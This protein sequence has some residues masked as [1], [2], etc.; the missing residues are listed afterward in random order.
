MAEEAVSE[1]NVFEG[2]NVY[3]NSELLNETPL[4]ETFFIDEKQHP[5]N[6]Y[7][8]QVKALYSGC[9]EVGSNVVRVKAQSSVETT[10]A[11]GVRIYTYDGRVYIK[12]L[13]KGTKVTLI[14]AAGRVIHTGISIDEPEYVINATLLPQGI[15]FVQVC[16]ESYKVVITQ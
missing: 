14:D 7:E 10:L 5:A 11:N 2:Y 1:R 12:G 4:Q 9:G 13:D 16:N 6:Y 15:Y 3:C 8:Y